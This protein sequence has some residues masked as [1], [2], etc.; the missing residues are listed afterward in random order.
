MS[1]TLLITIVEGLV[2][3]ILGCVLHFTYGWSKENKF[4]GVFSAVNE[5]TWEHEKLALSGIF[6]CTLCDVWFLGENPNYWFAKCISFLVP[7]IMIPALFYGYHLFLKLRSC[8]PLDIA[9]FIL[10]SFVSALVFA[11][12]LELPPTGI[13]GEIISG[14]ISLVVFTAYLLLTK[15][16]IQNNIIFEDPLTK[17]YGYAGFKSPKKRH[18]K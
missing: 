12:V 9:I 6:F 7:I 13:L 8:L 14:A 18:K 1:E 3:T 16:P 11:V 10:A 5:S 4:V 2:I 17:K 15:F